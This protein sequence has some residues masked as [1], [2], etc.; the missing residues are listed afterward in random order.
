MARQRN[1]LWR[2]SGTYDESYKRRKQI[3]LDRTQ[4]SRRV[5]GRLQTTRLQGALI[6]SLCGHR[7]QTWPRAFLEL[8]AAA[9]GVACEAVIVGAVT[10]T[11]VL[12]LSIHLWTERPHG[13]TDP[14]AV[15]LRS[16]LQI[17]RNEDL[18]HLCPTSPL[19]D[20]EHILAS[21]QEE[22]GHCVACY[23][24]PDPCLSMRSVGCFPIR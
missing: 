15:H 9:P 1:G 11:V 16:V 2:Y 23:M 3:S 18:V 10:A 14:H 12:R 13:L 8:H 19:F 21:F 22:D 20:S 4:H 6:T 5:N 17:V 24:I 7:G